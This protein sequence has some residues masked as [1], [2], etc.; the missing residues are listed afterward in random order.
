MYIIRLFHKNGAAVENEVRNDFITKLAGLGISANVH[1]KPLP[2]H[3]GYRLLGFDCKDY[4]NAC[5]QFQNE[6]TLPLHTCLGEEDVE[7]VI[8]CVKAV[9]K[10]LLE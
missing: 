3:T 7:Y 10:E 2:M 8:E 1:Y 9:C 5:N 6:V 4:P